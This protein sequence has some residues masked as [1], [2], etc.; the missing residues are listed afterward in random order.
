MLVIFFIFVFS[1]LHSSLPKYQIPKAS[2]LSHFSA[3]ITAMMEYSYTS[4]ITDEQMCYSCERQEEDPEVL[5]AAAI[6]MQLSRDPRLTPTA[7]NRFHTNES[8]HV[9]YSRNVDHDSSRKRKADDLRRSMKSSDAAIQDEF[10]RPMAIPRS[11]NRKLPIPNPQKRKADE[12]R[13]STKFSDTSSHDTF[14]RPKAIPRSR[15]HQWPS[16]SS[17]I[18]SE[19]ASSQGTRQGKSVKFNVDV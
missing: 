2:V 16:P 17:S 3:P 11:R 10:D 7:L 12:L 4:T 8:T 6:L 15:I 13:R 5:Q 18:E 19:S 9:E 14:D 1:F